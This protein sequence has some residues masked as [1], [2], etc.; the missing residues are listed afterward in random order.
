MQQWQ[1]IFLLIQHWLDLWATSFSDLPPFL[2]LGLALLPIVLAMVSRKL[3]L[4]MMCL[5]LVSASGLI[6]I[7]PA[8]AAAIMAIVFYLGSILVAC[9]AIITRWTK[10]DDIAI[11]QMQVGDLL[12]AEQRRVMRNGD[13]KKDVDRSRLV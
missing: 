1:P 8:N 3:F 12:A 11:L 10:R 13:R 2:V 4:I 5:I 9:T 7:A 6:F